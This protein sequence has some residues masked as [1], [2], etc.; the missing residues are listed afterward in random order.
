MTQNLKGLE[1]FSSKKDCWDV[2]SYIIV[3]KALAQNMTADDW[4]L[5]KKT[6]LDKLTFHS[7]LLCVGIL[8]AVVLKKKK[9]KAF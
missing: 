8:V 9:K 1:W 4:F 7:P 2:V 3:F 5:P 6:A